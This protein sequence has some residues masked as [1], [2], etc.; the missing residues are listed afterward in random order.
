MPS[1]IG[2]A[3]PLLLNLII[4]E[5]QVGSL[6]TSGHL[7]NFTQE[8]VKEVCLTEWTLHLKKIFFFSLKKAIV[9]LALL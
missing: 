5:R 6:F 2:N 4:Q 3:L 1:K 9:K 8:K 7:H